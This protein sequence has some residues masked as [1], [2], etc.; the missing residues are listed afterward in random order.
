M[1][2]IVLD[3]VTV[4]RDG[5]S[6]LD[7]VSFGVAQGECLAVIGPSG[8]G[9]TTL[10]RAIAGLDDVASGDV[11]FDGAVV[12]DLQPHERDVAMVFQDSALM[13]F[14]SV[15]R[16]VS[17]PLEV[18]DVERDEIDDRVAAESR[19]MS[20]EGL[21]ERMPPTLAAGHQQ[22]AQAARA[23]VRRPQVLLLDEP[24]ARVDAKLRTDIRRELQELQR[25]YG[26]TTLW[27]TNDPLEAQKVG[28]R[29]LLLDRGHVRQIASPDAMYREPVDRFVAEFMGSPDLSMLSGRVRGSSVEVDGGAFVL[30][31]D[32]P[33]QDVVVGV[34]SH[35]WDV[36]QA[37][38]IPVEVMATEFHGDRTFIEASTGTA[39]VRVRFDGEPPEM[40]ERLE[41]WTRRFLLF[42]TGGRRLATVD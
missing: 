17:S 35:D 28:D 2:S 6:L 30:P 16:N 39:T 26:V 15:R 1:A 29:I 25:G 11:L 38:G 21:L 5:R 14:R 42:G 19:A 36:V 32:I 3:S 10:L 33:D 12:D 34:R 40:G 7:A 27:A 41:I 20:I 8:S 37:G 9:K 22:L 31:V 24:L 23:L 4:R 18:H 13:P